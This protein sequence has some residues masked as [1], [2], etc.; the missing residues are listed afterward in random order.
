[1]EW[2]QATSSDE[3]AITIPARWIFLQYYEAFNLLFRV[4]NALRVFVYIVLKNELKEKWQDAQVMGDD[5]EGTIASL[6]KKRMAQAQSFGYLGYGIACPIMHLNSGELA[7]L[8]VSDAYWKLFKPYFLGS[9]EIIKNKLDEI[10]SVRNSLAHFR[11]IRSDDVDVIK[12]NSKHILL[13]I[14]LL[15]RQVLAQR[16][17]IPTNTQDEWYK[18]LKTLGTDLCT[19]AFYQSEDEKWVRIS[20]SYN[21][22]AIK[23]H[24]WQAGVSYTVLTVRSSAILTQYPEITN[25]VCYL[26]EIVSNPV[27]Q[28]NYQATFHKTISLVLSCN[29]LK[30]QHANLKPAL[31]DLLL[32]VAR[33]TE[34]IQKDNLARGK[35]IS[36]ASVN[37]YLRKEKD[38]SQWQWY[39]FPAADTC[40]RKRSSGILGK[41]YVLWV[42]GL[43]SSH[44]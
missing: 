15:V 36:S 9:K 40:P 28:E 4:E 12:Q 39:Y 16:D 34:L 35:L 17:V 13:G 21:S 33:E 24:P 11:P 3:G 43:H 6:A 7:R 38:Q 5:E 29:M 26:S 10:G 30:T 2:K 31:E 19:L 37:A 41:S 18:N 8:I 27:M 32:T 20:M 44:K 14:E 42:G 23:V 25:D 1:M 22:P